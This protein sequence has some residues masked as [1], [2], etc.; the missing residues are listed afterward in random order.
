[1]IPKIE[2]S[3]GLFGLFFLQGIGLGFIPAG[4]NVLVSDATLNDSRALGYALQSLL[5]RVSTLAIPLIFGIISDLAGLEYVFYVGGMI[6]M[7]IIGITLI[8]YFHTPDKQSYYA[9]SG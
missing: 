2:Q 1:M 4:P 8:I 3:R 5:F 6:S 7:I 9:L